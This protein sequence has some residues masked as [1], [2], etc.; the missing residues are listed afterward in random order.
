MRFEK[1]KIYNRLGRTNVHIDFHTPP[2]QVGVGEDFDADLFGK[3]LADADIDSISFFAK[4]YHGM[5]FYDTKYGFKHPHLKRDLLKEAIEGCH[6]HGVKVFAYFSLALDTEASERFPEWRQIGIDGQE[7]AGFKNNAVGW[8]CLNSAY[9]EEMFIPMLYEV[10]ENYDIDGFFFDELF[11]YQD[12]CICPACASLMGKMGLNPQN[13]EDVRTMRAKSCDIFAERV[14][15]IIGEYDDSLAVIY[16]P[17]TNIIGIMD[18][19][20]PWEN[21]INVGGHEAGWGYINMPL[22][23]RHVRNYDMPVLA[24]NCIFH[25]RWGDFGSVKHEAQVEFEV[26]EMLSHH[27]VISIGDHMRPGGVLEQAKYDV[28]RKAFKRVKEL[29][30]PII[31]KPVKDIAII[32]PGSYD[33]QMVMEGRRDA[34]IFSWPLPDGISGSVKSLLDTHQQFDLLTTKLA[35]GKLDEYN[36]VIIPEAGALDPEFVEQVKQ[37]VYN[38]GKLLVSGDSSYCK[39]EMTLGEVLGIKYVTETQFDKYSSVFVKLDDYLENVTADVYMKTWTGYKVVAPLEGAEVKA[40]IMHPSSFNRMYA[41]VYEGGPAEHKTNDPAIVYNKYGKGEAIYISFDIFTTYY[42]FTYHAHRSLI[43]N[44][45][46]SLQGVRVLECTGSANVRINLMDTDEG[47]FL[48]VLNYYAE[49]GGMTLPRVNCYPPAIN[50]EIRVYAPGAREVKA[51]S[52]CRYEK[53]FDGDY[54]TLRVFEMGQ[55]EVFNIK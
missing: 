17:T 49:D 54:I 37:Y 21:V 48:H 4:D 47:K 35:D 13:P 24:M 8:V 39:G 14:S 52:K 29:N 55:H 7:R 25:R 40:K 22:E 42:E 33:S 36:L 43:N 41:A 32:T 34:E 6:K 45:V 53:K 2:Y 38:G 28:I 18:N 46:S 5:A 9:T 44:M 23:A 11:Y 20:V 1:S 19:L 30:L 31:A 15:R 26:A 16:N 3:T 10:L 50:T 12:S 27:F 51:V